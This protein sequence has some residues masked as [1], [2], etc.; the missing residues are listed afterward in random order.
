ML[1]QQFLLPK[2]IFSRGKQILV[3]HRQHLVEKSL[4]VY[5]C[6]IVD[7]NIDNT[8]KRDVLYE[9]K[10]IDTRHMKKIG[11]VK[12]DSVKIVDIKMD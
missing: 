5:P 1:N 6:F 4:N 12:S 10:D 3:L 11:N 8:R 9:C 7:H 2:S